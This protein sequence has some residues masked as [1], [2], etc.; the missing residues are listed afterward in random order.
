MIVTRLIGGIGNQLFQYAVGR[1][2]AETQ[3]TI[4]KLDISGF[5]TYKGFDYSLGV[6]NFQEIFANPEE[7]K[8]LTFPERGI[9]KRVMSRL[10]GR[11]PECST[12]IREKY[13]SFDSRIL[14]LP[15][16]IYL[17]GYWQSEKYFIGS[18]C[19]IRKDFTVKSPLSCQNKIL[20]EQMVDSES[21]SIHVRRGY[22]LTEDK[23]Q[24]YHG[25]CEPI[26]F[27]RSIE[28]ITQMVKNP[29]FYILSDDIEWCKSNLKVS[30]PIT[31]V[32]NNAP[33]NMYVRYENPPYEYNRDYEDLRL[34]SQCKHNIIS[35][36]SFSWWGAWLNSNPDKIVIAPKRWFV[37]E[38]MNSQ[39][40]DLIPVSW[41]RI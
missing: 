11:S 30:C 38:K 12:R 22:I 37:D 24:I 4:L 3:K 18:E 19:I 25:I 27:H 40:N 29:H 1:H 33:S 6:F 10:L 41:I 21:V 28:H 35:N 26:Y 36:S 15:D 32:D 34:M 8:V 7:V 2:L 23:S 9:A 16:G 5:E 13:F 20:T 39:T 31:F 14:S 17:E